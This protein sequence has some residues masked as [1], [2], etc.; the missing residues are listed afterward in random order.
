MANTFA[1]FLN[2]VRWARRALTIVNVWK[3][4]ITRNTTHV[5]DVMPR[6]LSLLCLCALLNCVLGLYEDEA[7]VFDW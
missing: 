7:G 3:F 4:Y 2:L 1:L 6:Y 5:E